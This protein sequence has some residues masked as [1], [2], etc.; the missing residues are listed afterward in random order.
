[1]LPSAREN[2]VGA[3]GVISQLNTLPARTPVNASP[4]PSRAHAHDSGSSWTAIPYE[5][6]PAEGLPLQ[7][8]GKDFALD[9]LFFA[10]CW[11]NGWRLI[12]PVLTDEEDAGVSVKQWLPRGR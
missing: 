7:V 1:M 3:P 2:G 10:T 5:Q 4:A 9:L 6:F 11:W 12:R 8:G